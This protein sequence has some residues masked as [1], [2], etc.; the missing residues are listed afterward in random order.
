MDDLTI[1]DIPESEKN[2]ELE[3]P[4][5]YHSPEIPNIN[6]TNKSYTEA[7][8]IDFASKSIGS[9]QIEE[10]KVGKAKI[11]PK[12]MTL[13]KA[14]CSL[15]LAGTITYSAALAIVGRPVIAHQIERSISQGYADS[16]NGDGL[17][18][19]AVRIGS[20]IGTNVRNQIFANYILSLDNQGK[21]ININDLI[22]EYLGVAFRTYDF[23][24]ENKYDAYQDVYSEVRNELLP[25]EPTLPEDLHDF[26]KEIVPANK[27]SKVSDYRNVVKESLS[28]RRK[29]GEDQLFVKPEEANKIINE[30]LGT[31][32][33]SVHTSDNLTIYSLENGDIYYLYK[34]PD[35]NQLEFTNKIPEEKLGISRS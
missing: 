19:D 23:E 8:V 32:D 11:N 16:E 3:I 12:L 1:G 35:T 34:D 5:L 33:Y 20:N 21:D 27:V 6:K 18:F 10:K 15:I 9:T 7:N 22:V 31:I 29:F 13:F 17:E 25:I 14:L 4:K 26:V 24:D 2:K 28:Q 30:Y